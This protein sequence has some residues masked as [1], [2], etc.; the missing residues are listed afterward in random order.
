VPEFLSPAWIDALDRALAA[1]DGL[2]DL[3]PLEIEQVVRGVPGSGTVRYRVCVG[4]SGGRARP[5][6]SAARPFDLRLTTDYATAAAI[7]QGRENAQSALAAGRLRL[8]GDV[9]V[10][11]T[12]AET[13]ARLDDATRALRAATTFA[14]S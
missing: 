2:R 4:P 13:F 5:A 6:G 9:D 12:V 3:A 7:A 14:G 8:G 1:C 11:T 10:L